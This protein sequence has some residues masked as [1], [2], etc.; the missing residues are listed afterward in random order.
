[1]RRGQDFGVSTTLE[2]TVSQ[3]AL[4]LQADYAEA[5]ALALERSWG[6]LGM[7]AALGAK[8]I[9]LAISLAGTDVAAL[10]I[11]VDSGPITNVLVLETGERA[12]GF[13]RTTPLG[14]LR[15]KLDVAGDATIHCTTSLLPSDTRA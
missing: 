14:A 9:W 3:A 12:F 6:N 4:A 11:G 7:R 5:T 15:A 13:E 8:N 1:V 10:R 2:P